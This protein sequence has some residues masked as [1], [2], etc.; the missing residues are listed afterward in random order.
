MSR[1]TEILWH[2]RIKGAAGTTLLLLLTATMALQVK[3]DVVPLVEAAHISDAVTSR[4]DKI[5]HVV[6]A[7]FN[8]PSATYKSPVEHNIHDRF[9]NEFD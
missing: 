6:G 9:A 2:A 1:S 8:A 5:V 7:A 4:V 3:S